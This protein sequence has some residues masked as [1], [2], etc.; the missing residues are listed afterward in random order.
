MFVLDNPHDLLMK[1]RIVR[2]GCVA[3]NAIAGFRS[4]RVQRVVADDDRS[5]IVSIVPDIPQS[6]ALGHFACCLSCTR[7]IYR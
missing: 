5:G 3:L 7:D 4:G 1:L 6:S 2:V